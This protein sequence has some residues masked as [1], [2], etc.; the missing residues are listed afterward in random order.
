MTSTSM[1]EWIEL[2]ERQ[3]LETFHALIAHD[4][5]DPMLQ[6]EFVMQAAVRE[7]CAEIISTLIEHGA[8]LEGT[9]QEAVALGQ[10][11]LAEL[12]VRHGADVNEPNAAGLTPL[13]VLTNRDTYFANMGSNL[14]LLL[15]DVEEAEE[16]EDT[17]SRLSLLRWLIDQGAAL[18]TPVLPPGLPT[19]NYLPASTALDIAE[20]TRSRV[21][22]EH[23][24]QAGAEHSPK[25]RRHLLFHALEDAGSEGGSRRFHAHF[26]QTPNAILLQNDDGESLLH[27]AARAG[28]HQEFK[29]LLEQGADINSRTSNNSSCPPLVYALFGMSEQRATLETLKTVLDEGAEVH[30]FSSPGLTPVAFLTLLAPQIAQPELALERLL[31]SGAEAIQ[32][33]MVQ[34]DAT[35]IELAAMQAGLP[36]R[37]FE[38]LLAEGADPHRRSG[39]G[40]NLLHKLM[41]QTLP[42]HEKPNRL[43]TLQRLH[44]LGVDVNQQT[45]AAIV[46]EPLGLAIPEGAT[47]L[48][49]AVIREVT[50]VW[51]LLRSCGATHALLDEELGAL[52]GDKSHLILKALEEDNSEGSSLQR[53]EF[54]VQLER[55]EEALEAL[56]TLSVDESKQDNVLL[57]K[58]Q[59][60]AQCGQFQDALVVVSSYLENQPEE[61]YGYFLKGSILYELQ[62][63]EK[64]IQ[65]FETGER[66]APS[67]LNP[68]LLS[69]MGASYM[70]RG[71]F[72]NAVRTLEEALNLDPDGLESE[73]RGWLRLAQLALES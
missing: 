68:E 43:E 67:L 16:D 17:Q 27:I 21:L 22:A 1:Y 5:E 65:A 41:L 60:L 11:P 61:G 8:S 18:N 69:V 29:W 7:G 55:F 28:L 39:D 62:R 36:W 15:G 9:L 38:L 40:T 6:N 57:L 24:K 48:D 53:V 56:E 49:I 45:T 30:L 59:L 50:E 4:P 10:Q 52:E 44:A 34:G 54:L 19:H 71:D 70:N 66:L 63:F 51:D 20:L 23:L 35:P 37:Y 13:H 12:L 2:I 26:A 47:V 72:A 32:P 31:E 3:D 14:H 73:V 64:A 33:L 58:G 42:D 46:D 25:M